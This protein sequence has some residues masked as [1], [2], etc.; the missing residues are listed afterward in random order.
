MAFE[1]II[2]HKEESLGWITLNRPE[3]LNALTAQLKRELASCLDEIEAD[4]EVKA[5][6][7]TGAGKAFCVGADIKERTRMNLSGPR[8]YFFQRKT[9]DL[10]LKIENFMKPVIGMINGA[11][12]GGG[13]ELALTCDLRV[14]AE[15]ARFGLPEA[16]IGVM[17]VG[18]GTQ[19]LPRL[20][21]EGRAKELLF[22]GDPIEAREALPIGLIN[23]L[24]SREELKT[25]T[26]ELAKKIIANPPLSIQ[27]IKRAVNAG[28]RLDMASAVD[29]ETQCASI[30][31]ETEDRRE[32]F[33]AFLEKRP[34]VFKGR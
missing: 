8:F 14:A 27:F 5:V 29:F 19:R 7:I 15:N 34:P 10:F 26:V 22:I 18:G 9:Q 32:G 20:I 6:I 16:K 13:C 24:T 30:L 12:I 31:M 11:A 2:Y 4:D 3:S 23:R 25:E 33:N 28:S 17:P 21:G 1:Q